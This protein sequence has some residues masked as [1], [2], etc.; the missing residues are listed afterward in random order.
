[1]REIKMCLPD[2]IKMATKPS[3]KSDLCYNYM[4]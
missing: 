1:M 3:E 2:K 4:S